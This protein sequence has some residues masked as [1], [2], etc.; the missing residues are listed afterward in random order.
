MAHA[1]R[2]DAEGGRSWTDTLKGAALAVEIGA[3]VASSPAAAVQDHIQLADP[4]MDTGI[5]ALAANH[6]ALGAVAEARERADEVADAID[7][8]AEVTTSA[9]PDAD[10]L[11]EHEDALAAIEDSVADADDAVGDTADVSDGDPCMDGDG[12]GGFS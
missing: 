6:E 12:E 3:V 5:T 10:W 8:T 11:A 1:D 9:P 7:V 4:V 2:A